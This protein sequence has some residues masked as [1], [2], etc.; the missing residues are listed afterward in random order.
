M[1]SAT[2][3]PEL[4]AVLQ[5][6]A[7]QLRIESVRARA[8]RG[9]DIHPV[10]AP[11][12]ILLQLFFSPSCDMT[13]T[14]RKHTIAI[15]LCCQKAMPHLCS[16]LLGPKPVSFPRATCSASNADVRS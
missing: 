8:K 7:T 4:L 3:S 1:A 16:M 13:L 11:P 6:K 10:A 12:R 5:N 14:I 9:A 15:G 2:T